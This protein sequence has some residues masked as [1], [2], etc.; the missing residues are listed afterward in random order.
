MIDKVLLDQE[1]LRCSQNTPAWPHRSLAV[2]SDTVYGRKT[3]APIPEA[4]EQLS[5]KPASLVTDPTL[6]TRLHR[7]LYRNLAFAF[8][9]FLELYL[10]VPSFVLLKQEPWAIICPTLTPIC[11]WP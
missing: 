2:P 7:C 4:D 9:S 1:M 3:A 6:L 11:A 5:S 10:N 8:G